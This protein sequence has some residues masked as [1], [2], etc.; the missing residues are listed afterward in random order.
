MIESVAQAAPVTQHKIEDVFVASWVAGFEF[1]FYYQGEYQASGSMILV[2]PKGL[3]FYGPKYE[4]SSNL[5]S[6]EEV[7]V[8]H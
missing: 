3:R 1:F 7:Q 4:S 8:R 5:S 2:K 6:V